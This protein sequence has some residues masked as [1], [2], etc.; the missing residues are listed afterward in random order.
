MALSYML[1]GAERQ[2]DKEGRH[3]N[4]KKKTQALKPQT[5]LGP[6]QKAG[7]ERSGKQ[8]IGRRFFRVPL[9]VL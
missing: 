5:Y 1:L 7:P 8:A 2:A 3:P 9:M 4:F 6:E